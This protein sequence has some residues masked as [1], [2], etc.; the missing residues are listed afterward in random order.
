M[1]PVN[2]TFKYRTKKGLYKEGFF[3]FDKKCT[4]LIP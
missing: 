4:I 1:A 3:W 2:N